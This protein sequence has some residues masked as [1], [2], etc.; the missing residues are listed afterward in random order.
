MPPAENEHLGGI[1]AAILAAGVGA[2]A[3]GVFYV[4]GAGKVLGPYFNLYKPSGALSGVSTAAIL[5]WLG[6]WAVLAQ[7]WQ[8]RTVHLA[9][10]ST[11]A[12]VL[13][14]LGLLLTYPPIARLF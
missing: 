10:V 8:H 2:S 14:G 5:V 9:R 13:L 7:R 1:A 11:A 12:L 3:C 6:T 4:L